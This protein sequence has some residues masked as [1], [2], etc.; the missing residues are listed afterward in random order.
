MAGRQKPETWTTGY[1]RTLLEGWAR[2]GLSIEQIA[3][4]IGVDDSTV[5]RW[6]KRNAEFCEI[7]KNNKEVSIYEV[8]NALHKSA[9]GFWYDEVTYYRD[10]DTGEMIEGKRIHK[11]M[12]PDPTSVIFTLKTQKP[13]KYSQRENKTTEEKLSSVMDNIADVLDTEDNS[14]AKP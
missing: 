12:K 11:F 3:K 10:P 14:D 6:M 13:E 8:E 1:N 9:V 2:D 5:Y 7:I 4:N